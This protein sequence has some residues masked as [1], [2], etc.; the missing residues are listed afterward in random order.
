MN[1]TTIITRFVSP[2]VIAIIV[3]EIT[4]LRPLH[5]AWKAIRNHIRVIV[6][7]VILL[8][9]LMVNVIESIACRKYIMTT[10]NKSFTGVQDAV[11]IPI[12]DAVV[13]ISDIDGRLLLVI[14]RVRKFIKLSNK[15]ELTPNSLNKL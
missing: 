14:A 8:G 5:R 13:D 9:L 4:P 7:C 11:N 12:T 15:P 6:Y 2:L 10:C 1:T 3:A